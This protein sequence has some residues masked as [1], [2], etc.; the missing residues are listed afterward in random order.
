MIRRFRTLAILVV[1]SPL[2]VGPTV[3]AQSCQPDIAVAYPTSYSPLVI[4]PC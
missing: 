1:A 2:L 3:Y 4:G